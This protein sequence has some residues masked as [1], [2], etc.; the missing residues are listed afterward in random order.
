MKKRNK[1]NLELMKEIRGT[2][3]I[4]PITRIHDND[5]KKDKKKERQ[6]GKNDVRE[7]MKGQEAD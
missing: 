4:N 2:W 5:I 3:T 1:T 7:A 6:K